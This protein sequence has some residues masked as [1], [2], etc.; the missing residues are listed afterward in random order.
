MSKSNSNKKLTTNNS[1]PYLIPQNKEKT[2][3]P[4]PNPHTQSPIP[5]L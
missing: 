1:S 3:K 5:I 2:K 4:S